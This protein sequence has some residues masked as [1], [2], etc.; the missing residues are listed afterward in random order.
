LDAQLAG[1]KR[2]KEEAD[3]FASAYVQRG[4]TICEH[5]EEIKSLEQRIKEEER[6]STALKQQLASM[7]LSHGGQSP[8]SAPVLELS[9]SKDAWVEA[10]VSRSTK[11]SRGMKKTR[12]AR[13]SHAAPK[14][15]SLPTA[16][17]RIRP[18]AHTLLVPLAASVR[19]TYRRVSPRPLAQ[20]ER[21]PEHTIPLPLADLVI[22]MP[23]SYPASVVHE[24]TPLSLPNLFQAQKPQPT[25]KERS[26]HHMLD[27]LKAYHSENAAHEL[28]FQ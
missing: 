12:S 22:N 6:S 8:K 26:R 21:M 10:P 9:P 23:S 25:A 5:Q 3:T 7:R 2:A 14:A 24:P 4:D 11:K 18:A 19:Q 16:Y 1:R 27:V 17:R 13:S 20:S 28:G 15:S